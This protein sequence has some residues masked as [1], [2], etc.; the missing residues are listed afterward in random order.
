[1]KHSSK[2]YRI[3]RKYDQKLANFELNRKDFIKANSN[4]LNSYLGLPNP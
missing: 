3:C 2:W 4:N 1:M